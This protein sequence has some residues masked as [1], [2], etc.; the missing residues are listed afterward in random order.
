[1]TRMPRHFEFL[2]LEISDSDPES[3]PGKL[4]SAADL[5]MMLVCLPKT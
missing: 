2:A 3:E 1:M 4:D 5:F